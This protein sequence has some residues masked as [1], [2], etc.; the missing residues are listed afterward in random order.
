M[1]RREEEAAAARCSSGLYN[2]CHGPLM[3]L[4]RLARLHVAPHAS[5]LSKQILWIAAAHVLKIASLREC[6]CSVIVVLSTY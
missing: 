5:K 6:S 2:C 4:I 3:G 1:Q